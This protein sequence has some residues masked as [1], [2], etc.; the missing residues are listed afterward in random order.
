MGP[1]LGEGDGR[2]AS[3]DPFP[4]S[5]FLEAQILSVEET[6]CRK[7]E[8][9]IFEKLQPDELCN[10]IKHPW[11]LTIIQILNEKSFMA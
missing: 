1:A 2:T 11:R 7:A 10:N 3:Q 9:D 4:S 8:G 5:V 6:I